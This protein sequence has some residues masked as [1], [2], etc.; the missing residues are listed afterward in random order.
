MCE[1]CSRRP[2]LA[3]EK[4][5]QVEA[6]SEPRE[7]ILGLVASGKINADEAQLLLGALKPSRR[8]LWRWLFWP[9]ERARP[10]QVWV[11]ALLVCVVS[12]ALAPLHIRFDGAI[13][14]HLVE[15]AVPWR[16]ALLDQAVAWP[17]TALV[18]WLVAL[19][20]PQRAR[21]LDVLGFVGAARLPYLLAAL[22]VA[23]VSARAKLADGGAAA[24]LIGVT[25]LPLLIW[26]CW[27]LFQ[28][29]RVATGG[30]GLRLGLSY[31]AALLLAEV[32]SK[33]L[34]GV[35]S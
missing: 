20:S 18:F 17:L 1:M 24:L 9:F 29:L 22:V 15:H 11:V 30:R 26:M 25:V 2:A 32:G 5:L 16:M 35:L 10:T 31:F 33:L 4:E 27:L 3:V 12:V 13:D 21:L 14:L 7:K 28:G 23:G 34:L 8:D 6:M 19:L